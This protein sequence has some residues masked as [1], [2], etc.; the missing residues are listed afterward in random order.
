M[1]S[2]RQSSSPTDA[3]ENRPS[4]GGASF[5]RARVIADARS[6]PN[7]GFSGAPFTG[8]RVV[9]TSSTGLT[10]SPEAS[11]RT[12]A[13]LRS[14]QPPSASADTVELRP[15]STVRRETAVL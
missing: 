4:A 3:N 14:A 1:A 12:P 7:Q 10:E 13:E 8:L 2:M 6:G 15:P 9:A 5:A 11:K